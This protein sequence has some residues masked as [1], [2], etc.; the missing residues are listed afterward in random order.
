MRTDY[1][2]DYTGPKSGK[3]SHE[4]WVSVRDYN[5]FKYIINR[6]WTYADFDCYLYSMCEKYSE[7]YRKELKRLERTNCQ[8]REEL[9]N[10][11]TDVQEYVLHKLGVREMIIEMQ[12]EIRDLKNQLKDESTRTA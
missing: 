12:T 4:E 11:P 9:A 3:S 5:A 7:K 6:V 8:L 1:P 2:E 10:P